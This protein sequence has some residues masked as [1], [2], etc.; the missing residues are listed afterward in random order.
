MKKFRMNRMS[1]MNE[2]RRTGARMPLSYRVI[3]ELIDR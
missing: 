1:R 2:K 3:G